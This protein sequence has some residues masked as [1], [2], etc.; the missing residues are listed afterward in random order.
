MHHT[1]LDI[2]PLIVRHWQGAFAAWRHMLVHWGMHTAIAI[3]QFFIL[4]GLL[5]GVSAV[6]EARNA[7]LVGSDIKRFILYL[8]AEYDIQ[9]LDQLQ[10]QITL[11]HGV[12][13]VALISTHE[14]AKLLNVPQGDIVIGD[15]TAGALLVQIDSAPHM[16]R[17]FTQL[18]VTIDDQIIIRHMPQS[19]VQKTAWE[20]YLFGLLMAWMLLLYIHAYIVSYQLCAT[21]DSAGFAHAKMTARYCVFWLSVSA[22][23]GVLAL[24]G[25]GS[26]IHPWLAFVSWYMPAFDLWLSLLLL[27]LIFFITHSM[28][29]LVYRVISTRFRE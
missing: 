29:R 25:Y 21:I 2:Q 27:L 6:F 16:A 22:I 17:L 11:I 1:L 13:D 12:R 3:V 9:L 4:F 28:V 19:F 26:S 18:I 8:P 23:L 10:Q 24:V 20:V 5:V 15:L 14:M 7:Q